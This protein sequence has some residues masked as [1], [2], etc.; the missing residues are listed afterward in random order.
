MT[1]RRLPDIVWPAPG[2]LT[3]TMQPGDY[4]KITGWPGGMA[5]CFY[6][7]M[8]N[9]TGVCRLG[10]PNHT[11]AEHID[12]TVTFHPSI[13]WPPA[14]VGPEKYHGWLQRGVWNPQ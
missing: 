9:G 10:W 7:A 13:L 11:W 3:T 14:D 8:P 6:A 5:D 4:V 2:D 12:G 1:G